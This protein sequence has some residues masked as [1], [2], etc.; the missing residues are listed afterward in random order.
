MGI[1][2]SRNKRIFWK[3]RYYNYIDIL[4][5]IKVEGDKKRLIFRLILVKNRFYIER[6]MGIISFLE[7]NY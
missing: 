3:R 6:F 1:S 4:K 2:I 7:Y 5:G